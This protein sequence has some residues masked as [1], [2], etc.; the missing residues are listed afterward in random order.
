MQTLDE[1]QGQPGTADLPLDTPAARVTRKNNLIM[2]RLDGRLYKDVLNASGEL[3]GLQHQAGEKEMAT[4]PALLQDVWGC[5]YKSLPELAPE[6]DVEQGHLAN[7]PFVEKLL[8]DPETGQARV[9]TAL[10]ELSSALATVAAGRRLMQEIE[11]RPELKEAMHQAGEIAGYDNMEDHGSQEYAGSLAQQNRQAL[12]QAARSVRR[13]VKEAAKAGEE[14]ARQ[15]VNALGGWGLEPG[16]LAQAPLEARISLVRQ[17]RMPH[18]RKLADMVGRMRNLAKAKYD[19]RVKKNRDEIHSITIGNDLGRVLP[20]ELAAL[21]N[22][23]RRRDF[24]RRFLE[25]QLLQYELQANEPQ[26]KGPMI[27]LVDISGSMSGHPLNW[28]IAVALGLADTAARQKRQTAVVFVDTRVL[29][30]IEFAPGERDPQKYID[31]ASTGTAGGTDY[32]PALSWAVDNMD[33]QAYKSADVVMITDGLCRVD[34]E[35]LKGFLERK[36]HHG[37]RCWTVL[38]GDRDPSGE[39]KKWSDAVWPVSHLTDDVA[40]EVFERIVN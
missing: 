16:D 29:K 15:T 38:I 20:A 36:K 17:L 32:V 3:R 11:Q 35:W 40:G 28:A 33:Q 26:G 9:I 13:A 25:G 12:Q 24:Q 37:A 5:F 7:R 39:L 34:D 27:A 8:E 21:K 23:V 19:Q 18:V 30:V 14:E 4:W 1:L 2:D 10:D 6:S 31:M 22:P